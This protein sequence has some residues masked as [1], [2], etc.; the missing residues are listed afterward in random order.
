[1]L[2]KEAVDSYLHKNFKEIEKARST[3][4]FSWVPIL[5]KLNLPELNPNNSAD[6]DYVR[7]RFKL[8]RMSWAERT[9]SNLEHRS[10]RLFKTRIKTPRRLIFDIETSP[11]IVFSWNIGNRCSLSMEN[12]IQERAIICIC[13]KWEDSP[14]VGKL[15]WEAGNDKKMLQ[16]FAKVMDSAD[17]LVSH[18]GD[19]FDIRWIRARC[20][21]HNIAISPKFNSIDTLKLARAQFKLNSNKLNYIAQFLGL[22]SKISTEYNLWKKI[23]LN[24][25][26]KALKE[27]VDYCENDVILLEKVYKALK[28]YSPPKKFRVQK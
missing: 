14:I 7:G 6:R 9:M 16:E 21:Y 25:D 5:K 2:L 15:V 13:Y 8:L 17:E 4:G 10:K 28:V 20:M 22:G 23:C 27:M 26:K 24:K 18:N 19:S 1:M 11:N 3:S 12:I